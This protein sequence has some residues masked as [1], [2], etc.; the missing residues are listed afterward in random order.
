MI[1]AENTENY[2]EDGSEERE[3]DAALYS[4][5]SL[6]IDGAGSLSVVGNLQEGIATDGNLTINNG[7]IN[8]TSVDDGL[9]ASEDNVSHLQINGGNLTINAGGDGIDSNGSL[10]I[11]GGTIFA[12]SQ[13]GNGGIDADGEVLINGGEIIALGEM[14]DTPSSSSSQKSIIANLGNQPAGTVITIKS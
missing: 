7:T 1:I 2:L 13:G 10:T 12:S 4:V 3:Y 14:N 9:N 8:I 6:T 11:N 5:A